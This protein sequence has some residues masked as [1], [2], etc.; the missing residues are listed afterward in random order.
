[1]DILENT[2]KC[3]EIKLHKYETE[4]ITTNLRKSVKLCFYSLY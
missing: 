1:M 4:S 2:V 3:S